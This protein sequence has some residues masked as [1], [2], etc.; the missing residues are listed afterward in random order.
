[1]PRNDSKTIC[2]SIRDW[3]EKHDVYWRPLHE[4]MSEEEAFLDGDRFQDDMGPYNRDRRLTQIRGQEITD[5]I[6]HVVAQ[7]TV[8]PRNVEARPVDRMED[9]DLAEVAAALIDHELNNSW[10]GFEDQYEDSL[11][12]AREKRLGVVWMDWEPECGPYG[13]ILY[14]FDDPR[15]FRWDEGY[16]PHHPMCER[17][18]R[19]KRMDVEAAREYFKAP[20]LMPDRTVRRGRANRADRP[21]L[22]GGT[23]MN[24]QDIDDEKVTLW[25]CWY[26][27][28]KTTKYNKTE[29][30][31]LKP[32]EQY[33]VCHGDCGYRG[34]AGPGQPEYLPQACPTCGG[35]LERVDILDETPEVLAYRKGKR[36]VILA[37]FCPGPD[38]KPLS[39]GGW[40][41]PTARS[42]PGL[43][44][45]A[46]SK[47]GRPIGF[48][49]TYYMWDQQVASDQLRT[50]AL[51]Q[52]LEHRDYWIMPRTGIVDFRNRRWEGRDDQFNMMFRDESKAAMGNLQV[53][54]LNGTGVD[55]AFSTVFGIVQQA[56]TQYRGVADLGLTPDNSKNIA[57]STVEQLTAQG[58]I[59]TEHFNR[60]KNRALG[61]FYGV[62]WDYIKAT[63]TPERLARLNIEGTDILARMEGDDLANYDFVVSD[64]P[65]FSGIE[66]AKN[67]AAQALMQVAMQTPQYLEVYADA[68][69]LPPSI[70]R[71]FQKAQEDFMAQQQE[72][73]AAMGGPPGLPGELPPGEEMLPEEGADETGLGMEPEPLTPGAL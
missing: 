16:D 50:A 14:S 59:P 70:V 55:P 5:T 3:V 2:K 21:L 22:V 63:Y 25:E 35:D 12:S 69:G 36:L 15:H 37:P 23:Y 53:D 40:P 48:S 62:L 73:M 1:M 67:E 71:K 17:L 47:P 64:T 20:W 72:Q 49:D 41:I 10:K 6:R 58:E 44:I 66:K 57:A 26:K 32:E 61:K 52:V 33:M 30:K 45:T 39:D 38:D 51:Q 65:P 24:P 4:A 11:T 34:E 18:V 19:E 68:A 31:P 46:Y 29:P 7:A 42:F 60:R 56:L 8:R 9:P 13:E 54:R 28:D 43:F 27:R